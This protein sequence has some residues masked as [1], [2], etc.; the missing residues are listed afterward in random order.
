MH[1]YIKSFSNLKL[2]IFLL[3]VIAFFSSVGSIIEQ[4]KSIEFYKTTYKTLFFGI[5]FWFYLNKLGLTQI[6]SSWWFFLLLS[7]FGF[8]LL[9]C[10]LSSQLP[11]LKFARRYYFYKYPSQFNKFKEKVVGEKTFKT[12]L[13]Y[14]LIKEKY[15]IC[16]N[17]I[18]F[19]CHKG[20][21]GRVGPVIVHL[22]IICTL[23]G[24]ILEATKGFNAQE[25]IPKSEIFHIQN[26][27]KI[28]DFAQISQQTFRVNDF[29]I[30]FNKTGIVQQF[31]SDISIL[32]GNGN[33]IQRKTISVN[34]PFKYRDLTLYQTDWGIIGLRLK[35][36][37]NN[38]IIQLPVLKVSNVLQKVWIS[39]L[40][41]PIIDSKI[42]TSGIFLVLNGVYGQI[43]CY[44]ESAQLIKSLSL[45]Q[46]LLFN[47]LFS[48]KLIDN[49]LSTGI[50]IKLNP[51]LKIIYTAFGTLIVSSFI[52][53]ISFSEIW[54][55][56]YS[57]KILFGGKTNRAKTQFTTEINK[58]KKSFSKN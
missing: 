31:Q 52:S 46:T 4:D 3:L 13:S 35:L 41:I 15:S 22:S 19:Y 9:S 49:L 48:I 37:N 54:F 57:T 2:A 32:S 23:M 11:V 40:P 7:L 1:K 17:Q 20:L 26:L 51:G 5:P 55:L 24:S 28:G 39:W 30:N 44:N 10:T 6:Y 14:E 47:N 16:Q 25:F 58:I 53:Y 34:K 56:E 8:C 43:N 50:Q 27:V 45:G 29:W 38:S 36:G 12:Q 33:E 21:I 18:G 42:S